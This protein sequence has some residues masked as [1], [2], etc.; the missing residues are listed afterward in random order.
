MDG[1]AGKRPRASIHDLRELTNDEPIIKAVF[2]IRRFAPKTWIDA[3]PDHVLIS[4]AAAVEKTKKGDRLVSTTVENIPEFATAKAL[5]PPTFHV[6]TPTPPGH[7]E[8]DQ[9]PGVWDIV[10]AI[11]IG[12]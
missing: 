11:E 10:F 7:G 4:Y 12:V 3:L 1:G 8:L 9:V 5:P 6:R 2:G